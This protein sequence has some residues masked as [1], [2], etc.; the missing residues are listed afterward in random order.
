MSL[1]GVQVSTVRAC[2]LEGPAM[3]GRSDQPNQCEKNSINQ[4]GG[5]Y[6]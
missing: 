5:S 2:Y 1:W 3:T 4:S 6:R